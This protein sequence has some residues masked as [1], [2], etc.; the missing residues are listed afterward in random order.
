MKKMNFM[1]ENMVGEEGWK[2]I[3]GIGKYIMRGVIEK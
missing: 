1:E 3:W 2:M